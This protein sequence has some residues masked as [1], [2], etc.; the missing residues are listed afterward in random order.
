MI[1][2][3]ENAMEVLEYRY[4]GVGEG[5]EDMF[6]R[7]AL[8]AARQEIEPLQKMWFE[9]FFKVL[10]NLEFVPNT[11]CL[12]NAGK[13]NQLSACFVLGIDDDISSIFNTLRDTAIVHKTGGGTG[14][15]FSALRPAG[16][17]VD[18]SNGT[19]SGPVSFMRVYNAA[20]REMKQ[21]GVR[22]GA[23]MAVLRVDHPDIMEFITC[24]NEEGAL[25]NFN[26]SVGITNEFMRCLMD[27]D[28]KQPSKFSLTW[29]GVEVKQIDPMEIWNAI[30]DGA[31]KNGEPGV[32]FIDRVNERNPLR[33]IET[34]A[35]TNPCGE[36][37]L[38]RNGS[39]NLGHINLTKFWNDESHDMN[40]AELQDVVETAVRFL[41]DNIDAMVYPLDGIETQTKS[42]RRIGLGIMGYADL[43]LMAGL[44]YGSS[45]ALTFTCR[46]MGLIRDYAQEYSVKLG[47]EKGHYPA[48]NDKPGMPHRRNGA[49][50]TVAPTGSCSLIA[51]VSSGCE[52]VFA[53]SFKKKCIDG[54]I[55]V[56]HPLAEPYLKKEQFLPKHFVT[57]NEVTVKQ[58]IKTQSAIQKFVDSGISKTINAPADS[59]IEDVDTAFMYAW[60]QKCKSITYYRNG[61]R[62]TEAQVDTHNER[63][64]DEVDSPAEKG[65]SRDNAPK[66]GHVTG[67]VK[68]PER[69]S[70]FTR[71]IAT[72]RGK[73]YVTINEDDKG[74]PIELFAKIG[75]SGREDF[76]Y[77][78][79]LGRCITLGLRWGVPL[80]VIH[81]HLDGI[82]G[83]DTTWA[84]GRLI[85]SVPDAIAFLIDREY[86]LS[87]RLPHTAS[88]G[89]YPQLET[90]RLCPDCENRMLN[91]EGC[92]SC[93][94]CGFS[95]CGG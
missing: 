18:N 36:Q 31:H 69:L 51:N 22:R 61:S 2:L 66:R 91:I 12:I 11:P 79:A 19:A 94:V 32:I 4:L 34:L 33:A 20:T 52:P 74:R 1:Q 16:F 56:Y 41:D 27:W 39:C 49:L 76:A 59:T 48:H 65:G 10:T 84:H 89:T 28:S 25:A 68:R 46:L 54:H 72:G 83:Y 47:N 58:H 71:K 42:T 57:A 3:S 63:T 78:E 86:L 30:L 6:H 17:Q 7:V 75:K 93:P 95:K 67:F 29:Q 80:Q 24:K 60:K 15:D 37:P 73:L 8:T 5:V 81:K 55:N 14:F 26:I 44:R 53:W 43:L 92:E 38:P 88:G 77:T 82:T 87:N 90:G 50:L 64:I 85:K 62:E 45:K 35:A 40:W 23:N 13:T 70:G 21:G 9:K